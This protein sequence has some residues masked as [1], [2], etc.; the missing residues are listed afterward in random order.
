MSPRASIVDIKDITVFLGRKASGGIR[1]DR[2]TEL[3]SRPIELT[4]AVWETECL[5]LFNAEG[6][7]RCIPDI[8]SLSFCSSLVF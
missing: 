7:P 6:Y 4:L 1:R 8:P 3:R 2:V 5:L